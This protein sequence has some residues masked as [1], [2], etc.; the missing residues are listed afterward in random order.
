[1]NRLKVKQS[2]LMLVALA[3]IAL[4]APLQRESARA[5]DRESTAGPG[6]APSGPCRVADIRRIGPLGQ[7][8][9]WSESNGLLAISKR[10]NNNILQ[11]HVMQP[12]GSEDRCLT[13]TQK[14]GGPSVRVHKGVP[15]W[16]PS[17]RFIFLQVE[18]EEH[19]GNRDLSQPGSGMFNDIW[20]TT[21]DGERWWRLTDGS[22]N[23]QHGLLFPVPSRDGK[24]LVWAER[25]ARQKNP[26]KTLLSLKRGKPTKDVW[27]YWRMKV[28]DI[29][30]DAGRPQLRNIEPIELEGATFYEPQAWSPDGNTIYFASDLNRSSPYVLDVF[31][32][33]VRSRRVRPIT[34]TEDE[35]EE[36]MSLS[37]SGR[38]IV[39]MSSECCQWK[40]NDLRTLVSELY[41]ANADGSEKYQLT[42]FNTPGSRYYN[43]DA[44]SI[45][46]RSVWSRDGRR[47]AFG[48]TTM[49]EKT[50]INYRPGELWLLT[51]EG[52]CGR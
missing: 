51:F 46:G 6:G 48:R 14:P 42:F 19:P 47:V 31:S 43:P 40:T 4:P 12:D 45:A 11:V 8:H 16:H 15:H 27:G 50:N 17:G 26:V 52:Q 44:R 18:E 3:V 2:G 9:D 21:P 1:M 5:R 39:L 29:E 32:M 33:D 30:I 34:D 7:G 36:H 10:D 38:K 49:N 24:K 23:R 41:L 37:P 25:Y 22:R 28:A 13:C 35:W 20:V